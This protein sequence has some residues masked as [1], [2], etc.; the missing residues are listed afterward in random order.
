M[1]SRKRQR[2]PPELSA[3]VIAAWGN[4]CWLGLPGCTGVGT[5]SDHI[6]P[7]IMGGPTTVPNLRRACLHCN[8]SR[9]DRILSGYGAV[10][11][12]VIGPP[13]AGKTTY[14]REHAT[15]SSIVLDYG[16]VASALQPE[17]STPQPSTQA[18]HDVARAAWQGAF[19]R[20]ARCASPEDIWCIKTLPYSKRAPLMLAEWVALDY[21]VRVVDPGPAVVFDRL[22]ADNDKSN[23][24]EQT[25]RAWYALGLDQAHIDA[26]R[27]LRHAQLRRF[28]LIDTQ[29]SSEAS[30]W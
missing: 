29:K 12:M 9:A 23:E 17:A 24:T 26:S 2:V 6:V 4:D 5:T 13:K 25:V 19:S 20:A 1:P 27:S 16:A 11:H 15:R 22:S 3:Q 21:D 8:S 10:I 18:L 7:W 30:K 28:G 14:V